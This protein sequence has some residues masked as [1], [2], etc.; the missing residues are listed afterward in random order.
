[1]RKVVIGVL[2]GVALAVPSAAAANSMP[3]DGAVYGPLQSRPASVSFV[4]DG[5]AFIA[6]Y[7]NGPRLAP[8]CIAPSL[9][10]KSN[11]GR[12]TDNLE[13]ERGTSLGRILDRQWNAKHGMRHDAYRHGIS[14]RVPAGQWHLYPHDGLLVKVAKASPSVVS[15]QPW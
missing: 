4:G 12:L 15:P 1:M 11:P 5:F 3:I 8:G 7:Q 14:P 9:L 13:R 10:P 6:G 2:A